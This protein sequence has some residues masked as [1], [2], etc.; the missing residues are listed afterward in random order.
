MRVPNLQKLIDEAENSESPEDTY[1]R[2]LVYLLTYMS[3]SKRPDVSSIALEEI[4][5][6]GTLHRN[7]IGLYNHRYGAP[8]LVQ[9]EMQGKPWWVC[10]YDTKSMREV[11]KELLGEIPSG[12]L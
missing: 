9:L 7:V 6:L 2:E 11:A 10:Y 12:L 8:P 5:Q 3:F 1:M 4:C